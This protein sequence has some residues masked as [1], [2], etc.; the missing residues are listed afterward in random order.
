MKL[1]RSVRYAFV[2][3]VHLSQTHPHMPI[4]AKIIAAEHDIPLEYLLKILHQLTR[5]GIL[6]SIRGPSGGFCLNRKPEAIN[7]LDVIEVIDGPLNE[8][9]DHSANT[10]DIPWLEQLN[11]VYRQ[12]NEKTA[13]YL[14]RITLTDIVHAQER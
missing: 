5:C 11:L 9:A 4:M 14:K 7:L 10:C 6:E 2:A 1:S 8:N 13:N 3:L 12:A